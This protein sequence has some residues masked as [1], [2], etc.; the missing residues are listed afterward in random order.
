LSHLQGS[1]QLQVQVSRAALLLLSQAVHLSSMLCLL[2]NQLLTALLS[3][4]LETVAF[5]LML[6]KMLKIDLLMLLQ[7]MSH[8][9]LMLFCQLSQH[10]LM[11]SRQPC[12]LVF[13]ERLRNIMMVVSFGGEW[14][15][16]YRHKQ[17]E[18]SSTHSNIFDHQASKNDLKDSL[19]DN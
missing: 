2:C 15:G 17:H 9:L 5:S 11:L 12:R 18:I 10:L 19:Q 4:S 14:G 6:S 16:R 1:L 7:L 13:I 3:L 8:E